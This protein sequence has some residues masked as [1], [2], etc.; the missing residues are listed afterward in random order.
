MLRFKFQ[1]LPRT[2]RC[3]ATGITTHSRS[4]KCT[5]TGTEQSKDHDSDVRQQA[6]ALSLH[7]FQLWHPIKMLYSL[8]NA[9]KVSAQS[10]KMFL[11]GLNKNYIS[12]KRW[13][14]IQLMLQCYLH[15][16][17][18]SHCISHLRQNQQETF[19]FSNLCTLASVGA[20]LF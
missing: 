18:V 11:S 8:I 10:L 5:K 16:S 19:F 13:Y 2:K 1:I 20:T 14:C 12:L 7:T 3:I 15:I 6:C 4:T 9:Q 17:V